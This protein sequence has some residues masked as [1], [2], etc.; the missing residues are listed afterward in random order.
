MSEPLIGNKPNDNKIDVPSIKVKEPTSQAEF[1]AILEEASK[2]HAKPVQQKPTTEP[3]R[4]PVT[5]DSGSIDVPPVVPSSDVPSDVIDSIAGQ[6]EPGTYSPLVAPGEP[7]PQERPT[8][9]LPV[10]PQQDFNT[11]SADVQPYQGQQVYSTADPLVFGNTVSDERFNH[12]VS[13]AQKQATQMRPT[14]MLSQAFRVPQL[15]PSVSGGFAPTSQN[16]PWWGSPEQTEGYYDKQTGRWVQLK[17]ND[18]NIFKGKF[19]EFGQGLI[20]GGM[21]LLNIPQAVVQ[22]GIADAANVFGALGSGLDK[23]GGLFG[24]IMNPGKFAQAVGQTWQQNS[25]VAQ[26]QAPLTDANPSGFFQ[27]LRNNSYTVAGLSGRNTTGTNSR[28][29]ASG[30]VEPFGQL[31]EKPSTLSLPGREKETTTLGLGITQGTNV[32]RER[33]TV[34]EIAIRAATALVPGISEA[35]RQR[36]QQDYLSKDYQL[37]GVFRGLGVDIVTGDLGE[38]LLGG[39]VQGATRQTTRQAVREVVVTRKP[40]PEVPKLPPGRTATPTRRLPPAQGINNPAYQLPPAN[41]GLR[42]APEV[43]EVKPVEPRVIVTPPSGRDEFGRIIADDKPVVQQPDRLVKPQRTSLPGTPERLALPETTQPRPSVEPEPPIY[44]VSG[45]GSVQGTFRDGKPYRPIDLGEATFDKV[46]TTVRIIPEDVP[47][48]EVE[49]LTVPYT[50]LPPSAFTVSDTRVFKRRVSRP[51]AVEVQATDITGELRPKLEGTDP[52][53]PRL[54]PSPDEELKIPFQAYDKQGVPLPELQRTPEQIINGMVDGVD[55]LFKEY[56][57]VLKRAEDQRLLSPA[58]EF[59]TADLTR[60]ALPEGTSPKLLDELNA[61]GTP[62]P[63]LKAREPLP[64]LR[65]LDKASEDIIDQM[66]KGLVSLDDGL[67]KLNELDKLK[68]VGDE[69]GRIAKEAREIADK[70]SPN[71]PALLKKLGYVQTE[72]GVIQSQAAQVNQKV[73]KVVRATDKETPVVSPL[74][75]APDV[76]KVVDAEVFS[77]QYSLA[78][79][80]KLVTREQAGAVYNPNAM[81]RG[82]RT[83]ASLIEIGKRITLPDG[84]TLLP[85]DTKP[86]TVNTFAKLNRKIERALE[87]AGVPMQDRTYYRQIFSRNGIPIPENLPDGLIIRVG[88]AKPDGT[89][90][91]L[92]VSHTPK[93]DVTPTLPLSDDYGV[94]VMMTYRDGKLVPTDRQPMKVT[95]AVGERNWKPWVYQK[96]LPD[97]LVSKSRQGLDLTVKR[98][99]VEVNIAQLS[100]EYRSTKTNYEAVTKELETQLAKLDNIPDAGGRTLLENPEAPATWGTEASTRISPSLVP[101]KKLGAFA[102][103]KPNQLLTDVYSKDGLYYPLYGQPTGVYSTPVRP[104]NDIIAASLKGADPKVR[105]NFTVT[106]A[107]NPEELKALQTQAKYVPPLNINPRTDLTPLDV[108]PTLVPVKYLTGMEG[109]QVIPELGEAIKATK[110][111]NLLPFVVVQKGNKQFEVVGD[112][113]KDWLATVRE[114]SKTDLSTFEN[115]SVYVVK[116]K[117]EAE[118][119]L[120]QFDTKAAFTKQEQAAGS[121]TNWVVDGANDGSPMFHGTRVNDLD[122]AKADP[123]K[124]ASRSELG[125]AIYFTKNVDEATAKATADVNRHLPMLSGRSFGDGVVHEARI[126]PTAVIIKDTHLLD[127][128]MKRIFLDAA[129]STYG[130]EYPKVVR[131]LDKAL[132]KE[133]VTIKQAYALLDK[134]VLKFTGDVVEKEL[135]TTQRDIVSQLRMYGIDG[136]SSADTVAIYNPDVIKTVARTG[137]GEVEDTLEHAVAR[138]NVDSLAASRNPES[139]FL[140]ASHAE[141]KVRMLSE[142]QEVAERELKQAQER[143]VDEVNK[144]ADID[145]ELEGLSL[146]ERNKLRQEALDADK[147]TYESFKRELNKPN[148][149]NCL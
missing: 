38:K 28:R 137:I 18:F 145:N 50:E 52:N 9:R 8:L 13:E 53:A 118:T 10:Y 21:Q 20:S 3:V 116:S 94:A 114:Y 107:R 15:D 2:A 64:D 95:P 86:S 129:E 135:L 34:D 63:T 40:L 78:D 140:K 89:P 146:S 68:A 19:G 144:L 141:S 27:Q 128:D 130:F 82:E 29:D 47:T 62:L 14:D 23:S 31:Y 73:R 24:A 112:F 55:S 30:R 122:L 43:L 69:A 139:P 105:E 80:A 36:R 61:P 51:D 11:P 121:A 67:K 77:P 83:V 85:G 90:E 143:L 74:L 66:A 84:T 111:E 132:N 70:L 33:N 101:G 97:E 88:K 56:E 134:A 87:S 54:N 58:R 91:T 126:K 98:A 46:N 26:G 102:Q 57:D 49:A 110:G 17:R 71:S 133:G 45:D 37:G 32:R 147:R 25:P 142:L 127:D 108:H 124:G 96:D 7:L 136:V 42:Q 120:N 149:T 81:K 76:L 41:R 115:T 104:S 39:L 44:V 103:S 123:V 100:D 60:K 12:W 148:D 4:T 117:K 79:F 75:K 1:T 5:T 16:Q 131:A 59:T 125:T 6:R 113:Y 65:K 93:Q 119:I 72:P 92:A 106:V 99:E 22:G 109:G 138:L 48:V 35:E